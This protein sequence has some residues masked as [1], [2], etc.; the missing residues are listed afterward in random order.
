MYVL[1]FNMYC[2]YN[3]CLITH[4]GLTKGA[5][6]MTMKPQTNP[7]AFWVPTHQLGNAD[8][9]LLSSGSQQRPSK[10]FRTFPVTV[11]SLVVK[12]CLSGLTRE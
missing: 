3:D 1:C 9:D 5:F 6:F 10:T 2:V 12:T 4:N 7:T 8:V 11:F